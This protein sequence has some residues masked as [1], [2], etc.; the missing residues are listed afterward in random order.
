MNKTQTVNAT[1]DL[2]IPLKNYSDFLPAEKEIARWVNAAC[3]E[4]KYD[5]ELTIR[6]SD[7]EEITDLNATYRGKSYATNV[8]SFPAEIPEE[9]DLAL[10][11]DI[12]ICADVVNKEA[13]EQAKT[14]ESHWAHMVIHG[15]LHLL[16]YDH[17]TDAEA[18]EMENKEIILMQQLG[19]INPYLTTENK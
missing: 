12:V 6:I 4:L 1:V 7:A 5:V 16:G 10:L 2:Q 13:K 15:T 19:F 11:G 14:R 18:E 3:A 17:M 8:L 9:I